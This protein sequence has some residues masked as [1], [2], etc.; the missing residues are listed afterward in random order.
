[1]KSN[2]SFFAV[3]KA[4]GSNSFQGNLDV[5]VRCKSLAY[6]YR[7]V[8]VTVSYQYS[9][10]QMTVTID[11]DGDSEKPD[12]RNLSLHC[13]YN[14]NFQ[15]FTCNNSFLEWDDGNNRISIDFNA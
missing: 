6:T 9:Y 1:M 7:Q 2:E 11:W 4:V 8:Y 15:N 12:Y 13:G 14:S 5:Q 10:D 3:I